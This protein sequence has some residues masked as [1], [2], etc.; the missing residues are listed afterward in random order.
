[1]TSNNDLSSLFKPKP[2]KERLRNYFADTLCEADEYITAGE[3]SAGE[4]I[5]LFVEAMLESQKYF[6]DKV[7]VYDM[8]RDAIASRY[9][10]K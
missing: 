9:R 6:A 8:L 10:N 3:L 5:D 1:M 4:L 7:K 2:A